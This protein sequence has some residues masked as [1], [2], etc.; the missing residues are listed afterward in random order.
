M[1]RGVDIQWLGGPIIFGRIMA[2][3][4]WNLCTCSAV[5]NI[6]QDNFESKGVQ[7]KLK[8]SSV[9]DNVFYSRSG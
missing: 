7:Y 9:V 5:I 6:K 4:L 8:T 1:G 2:F 3:G